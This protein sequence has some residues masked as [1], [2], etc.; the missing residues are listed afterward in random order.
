MNPSGLV[1]TGVVV[2]L[3]A[4]LSP[5]Q[6]MSIS[7]GRRLLE[8]VRDEVF[9]FD[10]PGFYWF[11]QYCRTAEGK[12][13]LVDD[14]KSDA[15]PWKLLME[16]PG[17]YR[18]QAIVIEGVLRSRYSYDVPNREGVGRLHQ[19]ELAD[20]VSRALAAVV[21]TDD[22]GELPMRSRVRVKAYFIKVRSFQTSEGE[23]GAGPLFVGAEVGRAALAAPVPDPGGPDRRSRNYI[24][25]GV[26]VMALIWF[27]L[28][29]G[30]SRPR[31]RFSAGP[32]AQEAPTEA[33]FDWIHRSAD[34]PHEKDDAGGSGCD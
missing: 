34:R 17:D 19:L 6:E 13:G 33:D 1:V 11:C 12:A 30:L 9:S 28:R 7:E 26:V 14:G 10:D 22:P 32:G 3:G 16:R 23:A 18:G 24:F 5:G 25:A 27:L 29:R 15:V 21:L 4:A 31:T 20:A 2:L 8:D